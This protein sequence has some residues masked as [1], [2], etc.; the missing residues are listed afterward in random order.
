MSDRTFRKTNIFAGMGVATLVI[1]MA[2]VIG[3][4]AQAKVERPLSTT[5]RH[6]LISELKEVVANTVPDGPAAASLAAK[7]D[8]QRGL[9]GKTKRQLIDLLYADLKT[10]ID[11]AGARYEIFSMF[12]FY[13]T[14]PDSMFYKRPIKTPH[15]LSKTAGVRNLVGL[16]VKMHPYVGIDEE[17]AQ[18]PGGGDVKAET[19]KQRSNRIAGFDDALKMNSKLTEAQKL[20]VRAN[21][22]RL[23]K[24]SDKI[25]DDA[26]SRNFPTERWIKEGLS[27]GYTA[28]FSDRELA[29]LIDYFQQPAGR[30][31][32]HYVRVTNMA[33]MIRGNGGHPDVT[34]AEKDEYDRFSETV[35][36]EK[37]HKTFIKEAVE[38]E[39][40][41]ENAVRQSVP[42]ADGFAIYEP[43]NLNKLINKFVAE[44]YRK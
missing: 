10:V 6:N 16:T 3:A 2:F 8:R 15:P 24:I 9:T 22:D 12:S 40:A 23:I 38:Y 28:N 1:C 30:R 25:T 18:L 39:Q 17:L 44:N 31:Y 32:L 20:F 11:D 34:A 14:I 5:A 35:L 7:W 21:Y 42:N 37:F 33:Q 4:F 26:I 41:K 27:K 36:G 43:E 19:E 29:T 13:K